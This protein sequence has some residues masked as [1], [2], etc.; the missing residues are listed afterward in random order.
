MDGRLSNVLRFSVEDIRIPAEFAGYPTVILEVL[1][2]LALTYS[3]DESLNIELNDFPP[4]GQL[5]DIAKRLGLDTSF[6]DGVAEALVGRMFGV[7]LVGTYEELEEKRRALEEAT[8][9]AQDVDAAL[10][11]AAGGV[12]RADPPQPTGGGIF[13]P[14][15]RVRSFLD[16]CLVPAIRSFPDFG[17]CVRN[18]ETDDFARE[19]LDAWRDA[20]RDI[21]SISS[22]NGSAGLWQTA[23][24][25]MA[26]YFRDI[27]VNHVVGGVLK[28]ARM[29]FRLDDP[30]ARECVWDYCS[31]ANG[32]L[33]PSRNAARK[34]DG[35]LS[36]LGRKTTFDQDDWEAWEGVT[37]QFL[38]E[39]KGTR[40]Q[41]DALSELEVIAEDQARS[42]ERIE[43]TGESYFSG[44]ADPENANKEP[45]GHDPTGG[46]KVCKVRG[47]SSRFAALVSTGSDCPTDVVFT[48]VSLDAL[49]SSHEAMGYLLFGETKIWRRGMQDFGFPPVGRAAGWDCELLSEPAIDQAYDNAVN[50]ITIPNEFTFVLLCP[51]D[52][53]DTESFC[54]SK[55]ACPDPASSGYPSL[56]EYKVDPPAHGPTCRNP[57]LTCNVEPCGSYFSLPV[58]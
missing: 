38:D 11:E 37:E 50:G 30:L 55:C 4:P 29:G 42:F 17:G 51:Y 14:V 18:H 32:T 20:A 40:D 47:D 57:E 41:R 8:R 13:A 23:K 31:D 58:C 35:L 7:S 26:G 22:L 49:I 21:Q 15:E 44:E 28:T 53:D 45:D 16:R 48:E 12:L 19:Y 5:V 52:D 39:N 46:S 54:E 10:S 9:A 1:L 33:H 36:E 24:R 56:C 34:S 2:E 43:D 27:V 6:S 25:T 3:D